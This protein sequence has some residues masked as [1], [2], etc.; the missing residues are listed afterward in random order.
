MDPR[1]M[2]RQ[3]VWAGDRRIRVGDPARLTATEAVRLIRDGK[4]RPEALMEACLA[5][6]AEREPALRAFA[7]FDAA[8]AAKGAA[9]ARPGP[10]HGLPVGVKDVL[11]TADMPSEYGS[12]IWSGWRP[13]ADAAAVAWARAAG[14]VVIGKTVTTE[15]ATRKPGPTGNPHNLAHTPGGSSSGS[16]AG[17]ADCFFPLAYGTQTAGSVI[18]PAAY[19]G[20]VGFKPSFA[21]INRFGMK[22]MAESLDTVGVMARSVADCALFAGAVAGR[23]FGSPDIRPEH[24]PRIGI[25]RSPAWDKAAPET[26]HLLERVAVALAKAG[27]NVVDRELSAEVAA[28]AEAHG[29]VMNNESGRAMGWELAHARGQISDGLRER[30][31]FGLSRSETQVLEAYAA[32]HRAQL[33]FPACMEE[34]DVLV[35]PSAPGEAPAGLEWTGDPV[36]NLIWTS[37]HVPCVTVP[38][39]AGPNGLPLGIQIVARK[40]EDRQALA[41]GQW[42]SAAVA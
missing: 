4:L 20:V 32:F 7:W 9:A 24:A 14:G 33:A 23:D 38:A 6:I 3:P 21:T 15:F 8:A 40:G 16:A 28:V 27:A 5:R 31:E 22:V 18:R 19:C 41:W 39:G 34:L 26:R 17:V 12:P 1:V 25:C 30:L 11:D 29:I 2:F 37:L 10:L 42:V 13:R 36:F 35:T